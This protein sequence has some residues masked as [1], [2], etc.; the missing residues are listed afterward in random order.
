MTPLRERF[1]EDMQLRGLA[2]TTQ[3]SYLHYTVEY[4]KFYN[5]SPEKLGPGG[6]TELPSQR[7]AGILPPPVGHWVLGSTSPARRLPRSVCGPY[8]REAQVVSPLRHRY[9]DFH[10]SSAAMSWSDPPPR[11]LLMMPPGGNSHPLPRCRPRRA[12][13]SC[14]SPRSDSA[15]TPLHPLSFRCHP[16]NSPSS[17]TH[18]PLPHPPLHPQRPHRDSVSTAIPSPTSEQSPLKTRPHAHV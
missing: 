15:P 12:H 13:S 18:R 4:A 3:R 17:T 16:S 11:R 9:D 14:V 7:Q 8:R 5:T 6:R 10:S 1:I 2:T